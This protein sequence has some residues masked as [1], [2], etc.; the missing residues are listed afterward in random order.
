MAPPLVLVE[1][2]ASG[3]VAITLNRP[4]RRNALNPELADAFAAAIESVRADGRARAVLLAGAGSAFC[5]GGDLDMI[6]ALAA[7]SPE[8]SRAHM[9]S[10]YERFLGLATLELPTVAAIHGAAI[11]AG[12]AVAL[13]CDFRIV[14]RDARLGLNFVKLGLAPGMGST[15]FLP[16]LVGAARAADLLLSGRSIDGAEAAAMGLCH[17]AVAAEEVLPRARSLAEDLAAGAPLA[18]RCVKKALRRDRAGLEAA[19]A[20]EAAHQALC[21]GTADLREGLR[22]ARER[23]PPRFE[24]R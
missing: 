22:A 9:R 8:D 20:E 5:A 10:F 13:A 2:D 21:Y 18:I 19:L 17:E 7:A 23:R 16:R 12:L 14:A 15:Y 1:R 24:G 11:G 4:H 3:I 6:E